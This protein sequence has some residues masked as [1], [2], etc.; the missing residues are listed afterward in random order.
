MLAAGLAIGL[1]TYSGGWRI[2]RTMGKGIVEIETPQGAA[3]GAATAATILASAHL[4][5]GLS[6][7]HVATGSIVGSGLGRRGAEVRWSVARRMGVAWLLT[8]PGAALVG[9]LAA[10]LSVHGVVGV[11]ALLALLAAACTVIWLISRRNQI[12]HRNVT[13]SAEVLVLASA[14]PETYPDDPRLGGP[15]AGKHKRKKQKSAA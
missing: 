4:G 14:A 12:T 11:I 3:S 13:D 8:L 9:G 10:L 7:T 15:K 6:T 1:G 5:F 2:M